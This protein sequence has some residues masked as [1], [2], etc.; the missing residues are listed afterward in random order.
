MLIIDNKS[1]TSIR[2]SKTWAILLLTAIS[3]GY[4][5]RTVI[6]FQLAFKPLYF[7]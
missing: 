6:A 3:Q 5:L 7:I 1:I 2:A 4:I